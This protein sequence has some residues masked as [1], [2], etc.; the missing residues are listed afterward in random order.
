MEG[1]RERFPCA[2][3]TP[4]PH[5]M[6]PTLILI[7]INRQVFNCPCAIESNEKTRFYFTFSVTML[8]KSCLIYE[9]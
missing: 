4:S 9:I 5:F 1:K 3:P 8:T 6:D 2:T 7:I